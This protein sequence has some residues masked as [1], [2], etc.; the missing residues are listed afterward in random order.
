[1]EKDD[2]DLY[3]ITDYWLYT[4]LSQKIKAYKDLG[5]LNLFVEF[6]QGKNVNDDSLL[7]YVVLE[8]LLKSEDLDMEKHPEYFE[9]SDKRRYE[10]KLLD[11]DSN[12]APE[13]L[14]DKIERRWFTKQLRQKVREHRYYKDLNEYLIILKELNVRCFN[15]TFNNI[16]EDDE[17]ESFIDY[18]N[19]REDF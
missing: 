15:G 1:M 10:A 5:E 3:G 18:L 7:H 12:S 11:R 13:K 14:V 9:W 19:S 16:L 6:L 17:K 2:L 8:E 4:E